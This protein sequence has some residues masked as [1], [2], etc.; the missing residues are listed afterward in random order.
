M[1]QSFQ[2]TLEHLNDVANIVEE[3]TNSF[4]N[5]CIETKDGGHVA[6]KVSEF[7]KVNNPK[8]YLFQ[9]FKDFGFMEW[10]DVVGLLDAETGK[11]VF[12]KTH[13]II[14]NREHLLL[15]QLPTETYES[16]LIPE[17]TMTI[18]TPAGILFFDEADAITGFN[19]NEIYVD[20]AKLSFPLKLR[21]R[22]EGDFFYPLGMKGKKKLS[23]YF[24]DEKLS[25]LDKENS[26]LLCSDD[27]IVWVIG[28]RADNRFKVTENTKNICKITLT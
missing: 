15:A 4:L 6:F 20:K 14:K 16:I 9:V 13:R 17:D 3:S 5:R 1:L 22:Q 25:L 10:N 24:K 28:R 11:Q 12:S 8:A 26:W 19:K 23:K 18:E 21:K 2:S 27:E 7:K